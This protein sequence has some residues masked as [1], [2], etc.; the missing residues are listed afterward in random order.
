MEVGVG[1]R[2]Q[3][4]MGS[5]LTHDRRIVTWTSGDCTHR[6]A[7]RGHSTGSEINWGY[8]LIM[9]RIKGGCPNAFS[10]GFTSNGY[11]MAAVI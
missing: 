11:S 5:G 6:A 9:T 3:L 1:A 7:G 8:D 4:R 10:W 2:E